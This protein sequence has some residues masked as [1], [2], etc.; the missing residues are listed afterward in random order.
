MAKYS[1]M[2]GYVQGDGMLSIGGWLAK[3]RGCVAKYEYSGI[4]G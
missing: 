3:Y 1:G 2:G 4:G